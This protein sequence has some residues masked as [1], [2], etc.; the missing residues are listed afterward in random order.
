MP[1]KEIKETLKIQNKH[2]LHA[3]PAALLVKAAAKFKS[4]IKIS[5]DG[6]IVNGKSILGVM[7]LAA[8][9]GSEIEITV[10]GDDAEEAIAAIKS[11]IQGKFEE[12]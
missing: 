8:E 10:N 3:R 5:K 11:V 6:L 2:G 1:E 12:E 4:S 7:T 9:F